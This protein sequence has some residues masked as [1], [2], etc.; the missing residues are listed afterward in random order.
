MNRHFLRVIACA[1]LLL[2]PTLLRGAEQLYTCGM[3]PQII[4]PEPGNCPICG[5]KLTPVRANAARP[6]AGATAIAIDAATVQRMNLKT[7]L[8]ERG[9]VRR[10]LR[11]VGT[12]AYDEAGLRNITVKYEGWIERLH[13]ATTGQQVARGQPLMEVYSPDLVTAQQEYLVAARGLQQM[14]DASPEIQASM[15]QLMASA[16]MRL[17]NWDISADELQRLE[18]EG[19]MRRTID[20]ATPRANR[21]LGT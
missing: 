5:M 19:T 14:K 15:K 9:P 11:A 18:R 2:L 12:V 17:R 8:V 13:V 3:H 21:P 6:G 16:L 7:A 20:S 4:R 10:E 1:V